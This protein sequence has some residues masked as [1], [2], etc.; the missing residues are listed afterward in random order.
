MSQKAGSVA[1]IEGAGPAHDKPH[2]LLFGWYRPGTG[3]TRVLLALLPWLSQRF[4]VTWM[5]VGYQGER[6]MLGD[7]VTLL[8]TNLRGGDMMGAYAARL[9]W[10]ELAPDLVLALNDPWYLEHYPRELLGVAGAV[11]MYGYMP[12]D[13]DIVD[14]AVIAGLKGFHRL[15]TYTEHAADELRRALAAIDL[16]VSVSVAGHGVDLD[17]FAPVAGIRCMA[18]RMRLAQTVFDLPKPGWVVL[19][20]SRPDPRKRIDLSLESFALAIRELP[21]D[22]F[23][24]LHQ[25]WAYPQFVEPLRERA[26]T[27]GIEQRVFWWPAQPGPVSDNELNTLYNACAAGLNTSMGEGFGLV[28]FEHAAT[29]APQ[30]LPVHPAL[31]E[32]WGNDALL[33]PVTAARSDYSPLRLGEVDVDA[34][35]A[36]IVALYRD[37]ASYQRYAQAGRLRCAA[38]DLRW[39]TSAMRLLG[40]LRTRGIS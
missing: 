28:S 25:A 11:P 31:R 14:P 6:L 38:T 27:L 12:L 40:G 18:D 37:T 7:G 34:A 35:A 29:G 20:A 5:G 1:D 23:L 4:R 36:A 26:R 8:P 15:F 2:L 32:L 39:E 33:L 17:A 3:F 19:N 21:D 13:G 16:D 30:L 22:V 24:C 9:A 10:H